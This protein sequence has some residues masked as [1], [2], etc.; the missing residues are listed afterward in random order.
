MKM[1]QLDVPGLISK[2]LG[3]T[4]D[5]SETKHKKMGLRRKHIAARKKKRRKSLRESEGGG[6]LDGRS[7]LMRVISTWNVGESTIAKQDR[8][9]DVN[10]HLLERNLVR[11]AAIRDDNLKGDQ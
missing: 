8:I 3:H 6:T 1:S 10:T 7:H 2:V 5:I 4:K 11:E 9:M